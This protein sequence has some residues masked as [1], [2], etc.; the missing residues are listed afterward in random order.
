MLLLAAVSGLGWHALRDGLTAPHPT[1]SAHAPDEAAAS[2]VPLLGRLFAAPV[3]AVASGATPTALPSVAQP[4]GQE[5]VEVCGVGRITRE[6]V[7]AASPAELRRLETLTQALDQRQH[8]ARSQL[9]ARLAVGS[10]SERVAARLLMDDAEGAA[11]VAARS[12]DGAAYRLA[13][14]G[15]SRW[16]RSQAAP[17]CRGLDVQGWLQRAPDDARAWAE[18]AAQA[19]QR[20]DEA[21]TAQAFEEMMRRQPLGHQEPLQAA[22]AGAQAALTDAEAKGLLAIEVIGRDLALP[23]SDAAS[24]RY[25]SK[26]RIQDK[27]HHARCERLAR[28]QLKHAGDLMEAMI[29]TAVADRVGLPADQR[30]FTREQLERGQQRLREHSAAMM[31]YDCASLRRLGDWAMERARQGELKQV[32]EAAAT[33]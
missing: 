24:I 18:A 21:A 10:D 31:S 13:L 1:P 12:T 14:L 26:E 23:R 11:Q 9:S 8:A 22:M 33:R 15:C 29:A 30:P 16:Q 4:G 32:L 5:S 28:W 6:Q 17:S 25:C 7:E 19:W 27:A 20:K 3:E 2:A